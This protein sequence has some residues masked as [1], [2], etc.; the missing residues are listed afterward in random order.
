MSL[1]M[2]AIAL[3]LLAALI[4]VNAHWHLPTDEVDRFE[5]EMKLKVSKMRHEVERL[6]KGHC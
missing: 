3:G 2:I 4:A 1:D 5:Y 6:K